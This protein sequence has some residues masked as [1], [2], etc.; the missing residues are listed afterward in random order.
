MKE[1]IGLRIKHIRENMNL[2]K[3]DFAKLIGITGQY[4]GLIEKGKNVLSIEKL[5]ILCD[6]TGLSADYILFGKDPMLTTN[7][8]K[9]LTEFTYE[10]IET[11]CSMLKNLAVFIKNN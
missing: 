3:E 6:I 5:K 10:Q 1:E 7:T 11:G 2:T 9:L 8:K 4:L